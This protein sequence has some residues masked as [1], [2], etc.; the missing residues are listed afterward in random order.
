[1]L[2]STSYQ[3]KN[4]EISNESQMSTLLDGDY[5]CLRRS[6]KVKELQSIFE[7]H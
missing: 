6:H 3:M 7:S 5:T 4:K 1:V 2:E